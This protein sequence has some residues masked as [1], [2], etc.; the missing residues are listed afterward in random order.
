MASVVD[1]RA[2][3]GSPSLAKQFL[4]Q[5][6]NGHSRT[7]SEVE[8]VQVWEGAIT[9]SFTRASLHQVSPSSTITFEWSPGTELHSQFAIRNMSNKR[10]VAFK[11]KT[12]APDVYR[13]RPATSIM[14]PG[15]TIF[16]KVVR[17]PTKTIKE[18]ETEGHRFVIVCVPVKF[19]EDGK[20]HAESE[21]E[22]APVTTR[23]KVKVVPRNTSWP[24][25]NEDLAR[26]ALQVERRLREAVVVDG[27]ERQSE[28]MMQFTVLLLTRGM[29]HM[30]QLKDI[31]ELINHLCDAKKLEG[32][33]FGGWAH[34]NMYPTA[35]HCTPYNNQT[36][37]Y[38]HRRG[39]LACPK[40]CR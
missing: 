32:D 3:A 4:A 12:T 30:N 27:P 5:H 18:A 25:N 37:L 9:K 7:T 24:A 38:N 10:Q 13:V 19:C 1:S 14:D 20:N 33:D 17:A 16:V 28:L 15:T 40:P 8:L 26:L 22:D 31:K 11:I 2:L 23:L 39:V 36:T 21:L 6:H 35:A 29:L 34:T